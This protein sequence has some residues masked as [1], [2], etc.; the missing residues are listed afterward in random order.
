MSPNIS[1]WSL[2][3]RDHP[4]KRDNPLRQYLKQ[5]YCSC[6]RVFSH[7]VQYSSIAARLVRQALKSDVRADAMKRD[8]VQGLQMSKCS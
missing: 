2:S 4:R 7:Y 3:S 8:G 5:P 1:N 6:L